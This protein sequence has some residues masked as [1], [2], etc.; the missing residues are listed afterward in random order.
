[1]LAA[2]LP[3]SEGDL[4][5]L[6]LEDSDVHVDVTDIL[7]KGSPRALNGDETGLDADFNAGWNVELFGLEDVPHLEE[8]GL[9]AIC[10]DKCI[11]PQVEP[12][13]LFEQHFSLDFF[14][15]WTS[16]VPGSSLYPGSI[17][18]FDS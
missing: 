1:M 8:Q 14:A 15:S 9:L 13:S 4:V 10:V 5:G 11:R 2:T 12:S 17:H 3:D 7:V 6:A 18:T 16:K